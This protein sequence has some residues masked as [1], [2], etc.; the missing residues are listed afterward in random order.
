MIPI[1]DNFKRLC[2]IKVAEIPILIESG[3]E[4]L[5]MRWRIET[6]QTTTFL[7][8]GQNTE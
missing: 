8:I 5:E 4:E 7:M 3:V 6:N 2:I 1:K